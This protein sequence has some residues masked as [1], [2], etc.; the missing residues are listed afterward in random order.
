MQINIE[1]GK[2]I[3][4]SALVLIIMAIIVYNLLVF[5]YSR[6]TFIR[7]SKQWDRGVKPV[8]NGHGKG[9][10]TK[11]AFV[12]YDIIFHFPTKF[13]LGFNSILFFSLFFLFHN[14]VFLVIGDILFI[15]MAI[16]IIRRDLQIRR[17]NNSYKEAY[18]YE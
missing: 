8:T 4:D 13:V 15:G 11:F 1:I 5:K 9:K 12:M 14:D 2:E 17:L 16:V 7:S 6:Q 10:N 3:T 18:K